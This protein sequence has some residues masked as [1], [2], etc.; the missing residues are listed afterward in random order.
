MVR[1][2]QCRCGRNKS[3]SN[4]LPIALMLTFPDMQGAEGRIAPLGRSVPAFS[5]PH[6]IVGY[7]RRYTGPNGTCQ[8]S[9]SRLCFLVAR[10][11]LPLL[12]SLK[13]HPSSRANPAGDISG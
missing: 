8:E 9:N 5:N 2:N 7:T 1:L 6:R 10:E 3:L 12:P 4:S 13:C 11:N